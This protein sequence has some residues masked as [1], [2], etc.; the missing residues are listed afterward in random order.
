MTLPRATY[1]LQLHRGFT[2]A[3]A[4]EIVPYLATLGISHVYA[5]PIMTARAGS[6][7]G[8][9]VVDPT[10]IN[11]ELGGEDEF[12]RFVATLRHHEL[13]LIVDI[14]PNHMA[15]DAGNAWWMDVLAHGRRSQY[16][17]F[18][19]IDWH[20]PNKDLQ[21]KILLPVLGRPYGEA[22]EAGEIRVGRSEAG[23]TIRYFEHEFPI[24]SGCDV[25]DIRAFDPSSPAG[26]VRLHNLLEQ[27]HYRLAWW[28]IANDAI[29]WRR[30]FDI[31]ELIAMRVEDDEVF[32]AVHSA[33]FRLYRDGLIDGVR[34]DHIDGL[35]LPAQYC[36]K[37]RSQLS[38]L[39]GQR[40]PGCPSGPAYF[41]VEK[42]LARNE[43][44]PSDWKTDGTTGYDFMNE[45]SAL[46]HS[47]GGE[48]ILTELW[49]KISGRSGEFSAEVLLARRQI[50]NGSFSAQRDAL[51]TGLSELA[52][53]DLR[54]R[55]YSA[56]AIRRCLNE[57]LA[58]F[59][60]YRT[61]ARVGSSS[62]S[63]EDYLREATEHAES[64]CLPGDRWLVP[65][66]G[67][68]LY[69][70]EISSDLKAPQNL[71]LA[72]FQQ[73]SAPLCAKAVEDTAFY[74]YGRLIS[75]N[76]VG[77]D[78]SQFCLSAADFHRLMQKRASNLLGSMLATATHDHKRGEDVRARL[79]VLSEIAVSWCAA[80]DRWIKSVEPA[81]IL[82]DGVLMPNAGDIAILFQTIVGA[83]PLELAVNDQSNVARYAERIGNWQQKALREAKL[84]SSWAAPN[85]AYEEAVRKVIQYVFFGPSSVL[86]ELAAFADQIAAPGAI[87]GLGQTL[88]K[89][90]VPGVP[91]I[92]QG[93]EYWDHSLV[94]P[95]NRTPVDFAVRKFSLGSD[96][97]PNWLRGQ[98]KQ[99]LIARVLAVRKKYPQV[100]SEG[101]YV[102]LPVSGALQEN[103]VCFARNLGDITIV[104]LVCRFNAKFASASE[105][106]TISSAACKHS[107][108]QLPQ[109]FCGRYC[110]ALS[111]PSSITLNG[112][113]SIAQILGSWPMSFLLKVKN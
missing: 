82:I 103:L 19:D 93:A 51:V 96:S 49:K 92:Y 76:D 69:G 81:R 107:Y 39:E 27:Q 62:Q 31:N 47:P 66:L 25:A 36:R 73:L 40:P 32:A 30:F 87:N 71:A 12:R 65:I 9:D 68:W 53:S 48:Q 61:Y 43:D 13:G 99:A 58:H 34:V 90:T 95:D 52:S 70:K 108:V 113:T 46:Q 89:L 14:V 79:A 91:D 20:P 35:A 2:F 105:A 55:D 77:F 88:L 3:D 11:P 60:V 102:P 26:R 111:P 29:N 83:W 10:R 41:V 23:A 109:T 38:A 17:K 74:R 24:A 22:L 37:L 63:D 28:R 7:H 98:M 80:V 57:I 1:R 15:T 45:V 86:T 72:R 64:T 33:F 106:F 84:F 101:T 97:V 67:E 85:E 18:F 42:I 112:E 50:L 54:M 110:D 75:R 21:N 5:S 44:L 59:P 94:D 16:A 104:V 4:R 8:Y 56:S 78:P 100:F 6:M